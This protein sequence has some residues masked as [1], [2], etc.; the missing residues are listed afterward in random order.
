MK[1]LSLLLLAGLCAPFL[2][3]DQFV[4]GQAADRVLGQSDFTSTSGGTS[5]TKFNR[6][7]GVAVDP[8]TGKVFVA[9][10]QNFRILRF[11]SAAAATT[12]GAAEAVFGHVDFSGNTANQGLNVGRNTLGVVLAIHV[13]DLGRLWVCDASSHRVLCFLSASIRGNNPDADYVYGQPDFLTSTSGCTD[14]K[15]NQPGG[16]VVGADDTL[17]VADTNNHRILRYGAISSKAS[18]AAADG[19]LGQPGFTTSFFGPTTNNL[20]EPYGISIDGGGRLW[21]ADSKNHRVLRYDD[22]VS[23]ADG[24]GASASGVLGQPDFG[25]SLPDLSATGLNGVF[26]VL[27][28]ADGTVWASDSGHRRVLGFRNG[29]A[30][31]NGAAA[32]LV[33]GQPDFITNGTAVT[34]SRMLAPGYLAAGPGA[35][36]LVTEPTIHRMLRFSP[37]KSPTLTITTRNAKTDESQY[38]VLGRTTGQVSRVACRVGKAGPFRTAKGTANWSYRAKLKPG[39]NVVTVVA[40]GPGGSSASMSVTIRRR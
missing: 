32:D 39:R 24:N 30:K 37:V 18:G 19:V 2:S 33:L 22:A 1:Y 6:P 38:T 12:G 25:T 17:W 40:E 14:S 8:T 31:S 9:E 20:W 35:S 7:Q 36:L 10:A 13:D 5:A 15:L 4:N 3:A 34:A 27:A 28:M 29:A 26:A 16:V 23:L 11:S 21:V